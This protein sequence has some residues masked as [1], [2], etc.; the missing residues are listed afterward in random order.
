MFTE[1]GIGWI[2]RNAGALIGWGKN[3]ATLKVTKIGDKKFHFVQ[4]ALNTAE[5][6]WVI[7]GGWTEFTGVAG[8]QMSSPYFAEDGI[9]VC[10]YGLDG[11]GEYPFH[12]TREFTSPDD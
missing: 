11:N 4:G 1:L 3:L 9:T 12:I 8:P 5:F 10:E 7:D 6:E 2:T